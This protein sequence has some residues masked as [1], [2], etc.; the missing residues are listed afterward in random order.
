MNKEL[1]ASFN[2][3]K[4]RVNGT[5]ILSAFPCGPDS[6]SNEMIIRKRKNHPTLLLTFEDLKSK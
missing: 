2:H 6:L 5:I 3:F 4:D 1:V